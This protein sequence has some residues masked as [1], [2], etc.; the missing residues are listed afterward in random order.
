MDKR[1]IVQLIVAKGA[2]FEEDILAGEIV[3]PVAIDTGGIGSTSVLWFNSVIID[4]LVSQD[5]FDQLPSTDELEPI[6]EKAFHSG[7]DY[8]ERSGSNRITSMDEFTVLYIVRSLQSLPED[9]VFN[10]IIKAAFDFG[11]EFKRSNGF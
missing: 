1:P 5:D 2:E 11:R 9:E 3:A 8:Q 7:Y 10:A 4:V 6:A